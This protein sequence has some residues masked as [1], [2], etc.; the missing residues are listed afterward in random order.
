MSNHHQPPA[1]AYPLGH[2]KLTDEQLCNK[3]DG[4]EEL[5]ETERDVVT[6]G[7]A[8]FMELGHL[9]KSYRDWL[10]AIAK[11]RKL[12]VWEPKKKKPKPLG[13]DGLDAYSTRVTPGTHF[14]EQILAKRPS[15][16]PPKRAA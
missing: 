9:P 3:L 6:A 11:A 10:C 16:P 7:I 2:A 15:R 1:A 8:K 14:A 12:L 13:N 4:C 5:L